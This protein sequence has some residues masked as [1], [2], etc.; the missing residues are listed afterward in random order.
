MTDFRNFPY[1]R[2]SRSFDRSMIYTSVAVQINREN[3]PPTQNC[4]KENYFRF[5]SAILEMDGGPPA[6]LR[7]VDLFE[8][9]Q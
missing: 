3:T 5:G 7:T 1:Y 8:I 4:A 2:S 9:G 6:G